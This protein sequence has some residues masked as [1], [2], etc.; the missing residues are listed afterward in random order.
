MH[1]PLKKEFLAS[2]TLIQKIFERRFLPRKPSARKVGSLLG[3]TGRAPNVV[4][5]AALDPKLPFQ[6]SREETLRRV[7][8]G[9]LLALGSRRD[10]HD[11]R[12]NTTLALTPPKP[13]PKPLEMACS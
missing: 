9:S 3:Y 10:R 8:Q 2:R 1:S 4:A 5:R 7:E 6:A 12:R 11:Q 13:K